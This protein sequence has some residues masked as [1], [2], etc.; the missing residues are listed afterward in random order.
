M[1]PPYRHR[2]TLL[3]AGACAIAGLVVGGEFLWLKRPEPPAAPPPPTPSS[4]AEIPRDFAL[5]PLD[6]YPFFVSRPLFLEGRKPLE[7]EDETIASAIASPPPEVELT[8]IL[9]T[10]EAGQLALLRSLDGHHHYRLR[11]GD[12]IEGWQLT[13]IAADHVIL[14]QGTREHVLKLI[15]P[16][17][18]T[19]GRNRKKP[20][21]APNIRKPVP[22]TT[23]KQ[24]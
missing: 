10:P 11:P 6:R 12:S 24:P 13:R 22:T 21:N 9:E 1:T 8:G 3:L 14:E 16:R 2:T 7:T 23:R 19:P 18:Q 4:A 20:E 17:P 5:P 15:K